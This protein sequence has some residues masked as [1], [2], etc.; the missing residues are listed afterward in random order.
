MKCCLKE[1]MQYIFLLFGIFTCS[2]FSS[3]NITSSIQVGN[4]R[5]EYL[6]DPLGIDI[7]NPR[8][9]WEMISTESAKK[10][11]AYEILVAS[12]SLVLS[13]GIEDMWNAGK[14]NSVESNQIAY[15]GKP[16][17]SD[18]SYFWKVRVWDVS[19]HR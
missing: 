12:D 10:Q 1:N 18:K 9:S 6:V 11:E 16:L 5:C 8:F 2:S 19:V 15:Q 13:R 14:V 3:K 17:I 4:L 7:A